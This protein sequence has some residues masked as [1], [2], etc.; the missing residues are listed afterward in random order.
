MASSSGQFSSG[1]PPVDDKLTIETPEQTPLEFPLAGIGSRFLALAIDTLIQ[2]GAFALLFILVMMVTAF[3]AR[4]WPTGWTWTLAVALLI[5]FVIYYGYFAL[6][7]SV[8]NG[9]T[10]GKRRAGI[11]VIRESGAPITP[12]DSVAR[13]LLRIVDQLPS[14]YAVGII[15]VLLSSQNKRLGDYVAGTVVVVEKQLEESAPLWLRGDQRSVEAPQSETQLNIAGQLST[16]E[17]ELVEAFLERRASLAS[18]VR[19]R[20]AKQIADRLAA[21]LS[22]PPE[23][24]RATEAFLESL[25]SQRRSGR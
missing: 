13:N 2:L 21:R 22:V 7:E 16:A 17:L 12:Y 10:P 15:S 14:F 25:A 9:Q 1:S 4:F 23:E 20:M 6:F 5:A 24:R 19:A 18:E 11:R 8:W 3:N